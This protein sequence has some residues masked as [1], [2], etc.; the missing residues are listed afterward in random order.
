L[1]IYANGYLIDFDA[2]TIQ[3]PGGG[4]SPNSFGQFFQLWY[5]LQYF[6]R[7][8]IKYNEIRSLRPGYKR[9]VNRRE[10]GKTSI[11]YE[12]WLIIRGGGF[13]PISI[14]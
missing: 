12:Y 2:V 3:L 4:I 5:L 8:S 1:I 10:S 7:F 13:V 9:L 14:T 6:R 11:S